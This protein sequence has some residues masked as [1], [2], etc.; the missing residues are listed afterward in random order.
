MGNQTLK[1]MRAA[2]AAVVGLA[3]LAYAW[4]GPEGAAAAPSASEFT[5]VTVVDGEEAVIHMLVAVAPGEDLYAVGAEALRSF[6]AAAQPLADGETVT[7]PFKTT[8]VVWENLPV[9]ANYNDSKAATGSGTKSSRKGALQTSMETWNAVPT[10]LFAFDYGTDTSRC[11]SLA[12]PCPGSRKFDDK[13]DIGW[14]ALTD[15]RVLGVTIS[16]TRRDEFDMIINSK[17]GKWYSGAEDG[18]KSGYFD[19]DTVFL[20]ELGHAL[21]LDH[22]SNPESIMYPSYL[23]LRRALMLDDVFGVTWLYPDQGGSAPVE[24]A[25]PP[26]PVGTPAAPAFLA[27]TTGGPGTVRLSWLDLADNETYYK[28]ERSSGGGGFVQA[29]RGLANS[30]SYAATGIV[31]G[32]YV[33]RVGACNTAGC[34]YSNEVTITVQ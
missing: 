1:L 28:V 13:N 16:G 18:I 23:G 19:L 12:D 3:A 8:G 33:Y 27:G 26:A 21:G 7:T 34:A 17:A 30:T 32:M 5:G 10:S 14:L 20:H 22:T 11:P 31:T 2:A 9:V 6:D 29:F 15:K 24:G 4:G 25:P